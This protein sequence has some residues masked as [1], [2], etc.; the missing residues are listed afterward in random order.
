MSLASF[1]GC[2]VKKPRRCPHRL[3]FF[4]A[5]EK[6]FAANCTGYLQTVPKSSCYEK[7]LPESAYFYCTIK[8]LVEVL[9]SESYDINN[10]FLCSILRVADT[11]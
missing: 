2:G 7:V 8:I 6:I 5:L 4:P 3:R 11:N 9:F 1:P 10:V